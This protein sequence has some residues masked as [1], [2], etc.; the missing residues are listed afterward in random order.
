MRRYVFPH[1]G[2]ANKLEVASAA[3]DGLRGI[4]GNRMAK[5]LI[6]YCSR[7]GFT[8]KIAEEI[9]ARCGGELEEIEEVRSR[10]GVL[11]YLRSARE[12]LRKTVVEIRP[13]KSRPS[14]FDVVILGTPVWAGHVSS[15][16]RAY[17]A[18]HKDE[19]K[20][21][22]LFCTLGGSGATSVLA[23]MAALCARE[24]LATVAVTDGDIERHRF[25]AALDAFAAAVDRRLT[26]ATDYG[27]V[28]ARTT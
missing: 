19:L 11:G 2:Q 10:S 24:P 23:E 15:P 5:I 4:E 25:G 3:V 14:E 13:G 1:P 20:Q 28:P 7:T 6:V 9:G 17:V 22:A 18:A 12:A 26:A 16:M 21:V 8:R 27:G